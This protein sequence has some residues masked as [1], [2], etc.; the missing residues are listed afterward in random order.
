MAEGI[1][2]EKVLDEY[3]NKQQVIPIEIISAGIF[4]PSGSPASYEAI[5]V[6]AQH[7]INLSFHFSKQLTDN[8]VNKTDLIITM[9]KVHTKYIAQN[10]P[11]IDYVHEIKQ[12]N[13]TLIA[14]RNYIRC[15]LFYSF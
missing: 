14:K 9:E 12:Y 4:A 13:V 3:K 7:D 2:K 11:G 15:N 5:K 1:M 6:A 10:W 8:I